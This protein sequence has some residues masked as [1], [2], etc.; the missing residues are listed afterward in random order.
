MN[1]FN[2]FL[3]KFLTPSQQKV[4]LFLLLFFALGKG[5]QLVSYQAD[6]TP[7]EDEKLEQAL[8]KSVKVQFDL[9]TANSQ[10]LEMVPG[11]GPKTAAKIIQL[12]SEFT[13]L[14][15]IQMVK[16]I[17]PAKFAKL[18]EYFVPFG[19]NYQ[20]RQQQQKRSEAEYDK[21]A[22]AVDLNTAS[23]DELIC[24]NGIGKVTAQKIVDY[25][26]QNGK[27]HSP[28]DLLKVKGIGSKKLEQILPQVII[29]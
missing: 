22:E 11:I 17:G 20:K 24:I 28:Q 9:R 4:F 26:A 19:T 8:E 15:D 3:S 25:R 21:Q 6:L 7:G 10:E 27:F 16:G 14:E 23:V 1:K 12:R 13:C 18:K 29:K 2:L 5:L